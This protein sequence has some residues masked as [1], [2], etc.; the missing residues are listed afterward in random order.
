[1]ANHVT[2][3]HYD[4]ARTGWNKRE[5]RLTPAKVGSPKFGFLF[6]Q[7]VDDMVYAQLLYVERLRVKKAKRNAVFV[8]TEAGTI[9]AFDADKPNGGNPL[10]TRSLVNTAAGETGPGVTL[11]VITATP[12]IDVARRRMYV[13][14]YLK[15]KFSNLF[16]R[17]HAIALKDG[18]DVVKPAVLDQNTIPQVVGTGEPPSPNT[19]GK[20]Y[21]DPAMHFNR[22]ALLLA[23]GKVYVGFGSHGDTP[24]YHGWVM[25]F[26][27][28]NL[29]LIG[30]PYCSTPDASKSSG[31]LD[32]PEIGGSFW[33]SGWG[34]AADGDGYIYGMTGNG[35]F[36]NPAKPHPPRNY[37]DSLV[38]LNSKLKLIGS[39]TP[40]NYAFLAVN[41]TDFGSGGPV[42]I[43][44]KADKGKKEVIGCGK[45]PTVYLVD[46]KAMTP[47]KLHQTGKQLDQLALVTS[48][49][50]HPIT[51]D[52][53]G[54]GV[55][56]GPA[57]YGGPLGNIV[58]YCGDQG[59]L[60]AIT[61]KKGKL[62]PHMVAPGVPNQT[63][64]TDPK[65]AFPNE[66]GCI[67][68]VTSHGSK[69]HTGVVWVVTRP[70]ATGLHLR[71]YNA[72]DLTKPHLFDAVIGTWSGSG[73]FLAP[74]VVNG[75]V[76]VGSDHKLTV[77]GLQ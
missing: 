12:V 29:K 74:M 52:G 75:K 58:Y 43:P 34:L 11:G 51:P 22:A 48:P 54:P 42:V 50:A 7:S 37:A 3:H 77:Y 15:D 18:K 9:Y 46:R 59:P 53:S 44:D 41:D 23:Y 40:A 20:V 69:R 33:Q 71:A 13:I 68:V 65:E 62:A 6:Q 16:F 49:L 2:T 73:A 66:G 35:L 27:A 24:L 63:S 4:N 25:G 19:T 14:G 26:H 5:K 31:G 67:P 76:Y 10:W 17:L 32:D 45:D 30:P 47:A 61:I 64:M 36:I 60:Q 28:K 8:G 72:E 21:F 39:F 56:G 1:M 55:W 38:K 57:Y 70:D